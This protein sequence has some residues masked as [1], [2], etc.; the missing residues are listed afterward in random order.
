M[1]DHFRDGLL[2]SRSSGI[3]GLG[4]VMG[5]TS[6]PPANSALVPTC[7]SE[8]HH[9]R[10][11]PWPT[12]M[13]PTK[14]STSHAGIVP[15]LARAPSVLPDQTGRDVCVADESLRGGDPG[16]WVPSGVCGECV[17]TGYGSMMRSVTSTD[18]YESDSHGHP[19]SILSGSPVFSS[20]RTFKHSTSGRT[21]RASSTR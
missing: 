6:T 3:P 8:H 17:N 5:T 10:A 19:P 21:F 15:G 20:K 14:S 2:W 1:L 18:Q 12:G 13:T 9:P 11:A 4:Q 16:G 7:S